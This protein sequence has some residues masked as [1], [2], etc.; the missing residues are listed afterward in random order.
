MRSFTII[1]K[2][3]VGAKVAGVGVVMTDVAG[4][5]VVRVGTGV[6]AVRAVVY[7]VVDVADATTLLQ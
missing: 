4:V 3:G 7:M 1:H 5:P 6:L 2:P